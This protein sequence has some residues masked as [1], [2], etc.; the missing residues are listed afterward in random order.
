M[1][2]QYHLTKGE[3]YPLGVSVYQ[4][5]VNFAVVM[6]TREECGVLLYDKLSKK[7]VARLPFHD[8]GR[9]GNIR[10]GAI[11]QLAADSFLYLFYSGDKEVVDPY[12]KC[13]YKADRLYCELVDT[14]Y[15]WEDD[16]EL[17]I[18][19]QDSIF[20]LLHVKGF[21]RHRS[22]G[23]EHKG[24]FHGIMEKIPYLKELGITA[25]ELMPCYE[26]RED[27]GQTEQDAL[28]AYMRKRYK[29]AE[30]TLVKQKKKVNYWGYQNG[31]YFAPKRTYAAQDKPDVELKDMIKALH[32]NGIEVIMQFY[33]P[34]NVKHGYI[35]EVLK[36]WILE[37]HIDGIHLKGEQLPV[38]LLATDPLFANVKL[39]YHDFPMQ[40]I[41]EPRE[42][43]IYKNLAYYRD[44]FMY[45]VR[46]F[47][48]GD[49]NT[50]GSFTDYMR[51]NPQKAGTINFITNYY[52]F[53]LFDLVTYDR[54]HNEGNGEE[55]RDGTDFNFSWNCGIEGKSRKKAVNLLRQRQMKNALAMV[56]LAQGTPLLRAGDEFMH[57]QGGNNNPYCQDN[58]IS[59]L[60]WENMEKEPAF[61]EY[62]K[63]LI[64]FRKAH[65]VLRPEEASRLTDFLSCGYPDLSYHGEEAWKPGMENYNHQIGMMYCGSYAETEEKGKDHSIYLAYNMHWQ[66][67]YFALP[68]LPDGK[69]WELVFATGEQQRSERKGKTGKEEVLLGARTTAVYIGR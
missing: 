51:R 7:E 26:L 21:T 11:E 46:K 24:T 69:K 16:A 61:F 20:Y 17:R 6:N 22:S 43:P 41:Y 27:S 53:T 2:S 28:P 5:K 38:T 34:Q 54:K 37:Y 67:Q 55:N 44:D 59:W 66:K 4:N 56:F 25:L 10:Y 3:P 9:K 23:V 64:A 32:Q 1:Q 68:K 14:S 15:D 40:E 42:Q 58:D 13:L 29:D 36:Y 19:Y 63:N 49:D 65:P 52:G 48:K 18:P 47:L 35:L 57:T 50:L 62:V 31:Y 39:L 8:K 33:F 30:K 60:H 45:D 12:A